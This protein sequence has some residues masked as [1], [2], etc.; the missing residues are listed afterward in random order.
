MVYTGSHSISWLIN[1][2]ATRTIFDAILCNMTLNSSIHNKRKENT[3]WCRS[4]ECNC[5]GGWALWT[6]GQNITPALISFS[7]LFLGFNKNLTP[8]PGNSLA[9]P[10]RGERS[11]ETQT[12]ACGPCP[13]WDCEQAKMC[14]NQRF[15][16]SESILTVFRF[17]SY[18]SGKLAAFSW[19]FEAFMQSRRSWE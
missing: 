3:I 12:P 7:L 16:T 2:E 14:V 9:K 15:S 10:Q 18:L 13:W 4:L 5:W 6:S 8:S 19:E 17:K 11:L 1:T